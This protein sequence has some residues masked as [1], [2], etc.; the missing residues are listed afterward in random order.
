MRPPGRVTIAACVTSSA[1][2]TA[3]IAASPGAARDLEHARDDILARR[4]DRDATARGGAR[5]PTGIGVDRDHLGRAAH[6]RATLAE[7]PHRSATE[8]HDA[9]AGRDLRE[10]GPHEAGRQY[11]G[12]EEALL[13]VEP[14]RHLE[15]VDVGERHAHRLRLAAVVD[16]AE[17]E[18]VGHGAAL[19]RHRAPAVD[20]AAARGATPATDGARDQDPIALGHTRDRAARVL[21]GAEEL[22]AD[23]EAVGAERRVEVPEMEVR[24]A[25]RGALDAN[26]HV[27]VGLEPGVGHRL[28]PHVFLAVIDDRSHKGTEYPIATAP[29]PFDLACRP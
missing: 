17:S 23:H 25:D 27:G 11:V 8:H 16:R 5:K 18:H 20:A 19:A 10:L 12:E 6:L 1:L 2:P 3:S 7:G 22:V 26:Q 14:G 29:A 21:D 24:A 9:I 15:A 4:I 13:V 28:D